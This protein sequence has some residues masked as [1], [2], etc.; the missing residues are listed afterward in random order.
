MSKPQ[1]DRLA[2]DLEAEFGDR[3]RWVASFDSDDYT[4]DVRYVREDLKSDLSGLELDTIIHRSMA[5]FNR[6]HVEDVYF[7][8]GDAESLLVRHERATALHLYLS[9][10]RGVVVK[11]EADASFR[12]PDFLDECVGTLRGE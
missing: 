9:R 4:Y 1:Y 5:V 11:L 3:L 10:N 12:Y 7:H 2:A 6:E 8:L